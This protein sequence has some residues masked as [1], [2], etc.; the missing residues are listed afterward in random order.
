MTTRNRVIH[1]NLLNEFQV[2]D[3]EIEDL[4]LA[5]NWFERTATTL[6]TETVK[7]IEWDQERVDRFV[8]LVP[9]DKRGIFVDRLMEV[10]NLAEDDLRSAKQ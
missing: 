8:A 9:A 3:S 4:N 10:L 7:A 6:M 1:P 2:R 5:L